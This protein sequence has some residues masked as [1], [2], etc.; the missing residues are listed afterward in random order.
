MTSPDSL[1]WLQE[2]TALGIL[3]PTV[4]EAISAVIKEQII[5]AFLKSNHSPPI[6]DNNK[7]QLL[8]FNGVFVFLLGVT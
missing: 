3:S 1:V 2:R 6:G 7:Y 4:L 5:Q 8:N